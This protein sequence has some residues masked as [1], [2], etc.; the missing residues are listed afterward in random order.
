M[1]LYLEGKT[2]LDANDLSPKSRNNAADGSSSSRLR[3]GNI[4]HHK[5]EARE[6]APRVHGEVKYGNASVSETIG[7]VGAQESAVCR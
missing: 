6:L 2:P 5:F 7:D 4:D 1:A 3:L